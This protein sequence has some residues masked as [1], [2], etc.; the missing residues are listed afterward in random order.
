MALSPL[1]DSAARR[2]EIHTCS[3]RPARLESPVRIGAGGRNRTDMESP[4]EDFENNECLVV[5]VSY[6][7]NFLVNSPVS[8]IKLI[9]PTLV[10]LGEIWYPSNPFRHKMGTIY[11]LGN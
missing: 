2:L 11:G 5:P 10:R 7:T 6:H 8:S 4:P 3:S 1:C 9:K